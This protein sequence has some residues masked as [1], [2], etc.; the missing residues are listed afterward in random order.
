MKEIKYLIKPFKMDIPELKKLMKLGEDKCLICKQG[1]KLNCNALYLPCHHLF[2]RE[3]VL[4]WLKDNERCPTCRALFY[5]GGE[6]YSNLMK[7]HP[8]WDEIDLFFLF[9][10]VENDQYNDFY[11]ENTNDNNNNEIEDD[12]EE[13]ENEQE[14]SF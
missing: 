13:E 4:K 3:C 7:N 1:F 11:Y 9:Q 12:N 2:H 5:F 6:R 14:D 8:Y 10:E